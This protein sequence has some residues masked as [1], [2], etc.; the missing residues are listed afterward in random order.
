LGLSAQAV[1]AFRYKGLGYQS[2]AI[3]ELDC[4]RR[5][6]A[7]ILAI[8]PGVEQIVASAWFNM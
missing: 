6:A 5:R 2:L 1:A 8:A 3:Y 4:V 7:P